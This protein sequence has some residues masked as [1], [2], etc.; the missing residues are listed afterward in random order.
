MSNLYT[1][2]LRHKFCLLQPLVQ[3][4]TYLATLQKDYSLAAVVTSAGICGH[5]ETFVSIENSW[6]A[7]SCGVWPPS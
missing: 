3:D 5:S 6:G 4:Y 1:H 7:A 2:G